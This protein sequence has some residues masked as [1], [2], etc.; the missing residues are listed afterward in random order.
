MA[1]HVASGWH[2]LL[3]DE[4]L[5]YLPDDCMRREDHIAKPHLYTELSLLRGS[6][7]RKILV[8]CYAGK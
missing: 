7:H 6:E 2:D 8:D 3:S 4:S 1:L 5:R